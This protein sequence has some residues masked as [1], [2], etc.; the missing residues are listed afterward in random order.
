ML[1]GSIL[2][3]ISCAV[4]KVG[5]ACFFAAR[6]FKFRLRQHRVGRDQQQGERAGKHGAGGV[7]VPLSRM[8]SYALRAFSADF[9]KDLSVLMPRM[10]M[11]SS[12]L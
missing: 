9:S 7:A 8:A 1:T 12:T 4:V 10:R 3:N 2:L 6:C 5:N 11:A